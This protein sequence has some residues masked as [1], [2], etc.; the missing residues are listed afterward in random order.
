MNRNQI[1]PGQWKI[2]KF[3]SCVVSD[4][5]LNNA[6]KS[7]V[8][9]N[10]QESIDYYGGVLICES[11]RLADAKLVVGAKDLFKALQI[12]IG[13]VDRAPQ[14]YSPAEKIDIARAALN[15]IPINENDLKS[16]PVTFVFDF[17]HL[18][19]AL[20]A[21]GLKMI[22]T[23]EEHPTL[24]EAEILQL[25]VLSNCLTTF[26]QNNGQLFQ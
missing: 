14:I 10:T 18:F 2:G 25:K 7:V 21:E 6:P 20:L 8:E 1:T 13:D 5:P 22:L 3:G 12:M 26:K 11:I 16:S 17:P 4:T 19:N 23:N 9:Q 15:G 24:T